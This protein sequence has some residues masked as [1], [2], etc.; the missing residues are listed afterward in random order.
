MSSPNLAKKVLHIGSTR[1]ILSSRYHC[2][3]IKKFELTVFVK[4]E[5]VWGHGC[6]CDR[7]LLHTQNSFYFIFFGS[8]G[9]QIAIPKVKLVRNQAGTFRL[10]AFFWISFP[11]ER[12]VWG[13]RISQLNEDFYETHSMNMDKLFI[14]P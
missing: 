11:V 4:L 6:L 5:Q 13:P 8:Y 12:P 7:S 1:C 14:T 9:I 10:K 2:Q 3:K